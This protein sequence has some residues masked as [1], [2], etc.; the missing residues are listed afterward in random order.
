MSKVEVG[1]EFLSSGDLGKEEFIQPHPKACTPTSM[2]YLISM[3]TGQRFKDVLDL[4]LGDNF[5][6]NRLYSENRG[7]SLSLMVEVVNSLYFSLGVRAHLI[8][9]EKKP[10][11]DPP[12]MIYVKQLPL[13]EG[14]ELAQV[15]SIEL[16]KQI[17]S[18]VE[19]DGAWVYP[20]DHTIV[21]AKFNRD[22][23]VYFDSLIGEEITTVRA[24]LDDG[25]EDKGQ[26]IKARKK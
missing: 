23:V 16:G 11:A 1:Y 26:L 10:Q 15:E 20:H 14:L 13:V 3:T 25:L 18:L 7:V 5:V 9:W 2:A 8:S 21:V 4:L 19:H 17:G 22:R 6:S 12:F 24:S